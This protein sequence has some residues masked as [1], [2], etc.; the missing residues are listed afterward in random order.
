MPTLIISNKEMKDI[1]KI[2]RSLEESGLLTEGVGKAIEKLKKEQ[3]SGFLGILLDTLAVNA[4]GN[5]LAVKAKIQGGG[6]IRVGEGTTREG[7]DF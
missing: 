2:V 1:M 3:K 6:V 7:Q 4:I 5:I